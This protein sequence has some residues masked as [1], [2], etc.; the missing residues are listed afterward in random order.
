MI[1]R[2]VG[3]GS[4]KAILFLLPF[5]F[6]HFAG[7]RESMEQMQYMKFLMEH[8]LEMILVFD[9]AGTISYANTAVREKLQ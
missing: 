9:R 7:K 6:V 5:L 2:S 4:E 8:A 3:F 1:V